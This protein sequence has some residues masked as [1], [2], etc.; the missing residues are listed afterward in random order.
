ML[1]FEK[2]H[3]KGSYK[4]AKIEDGNPNIRFPTRRNSKGL[5]NLLLNRARH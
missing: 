3:P 5:K 1:N 2:D 4:I